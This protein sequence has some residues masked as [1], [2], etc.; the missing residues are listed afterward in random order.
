MAVQVIAFLL[1]V[2]HYLF[3]GTANSGGYARRSVVQ[4]IGVAGQVI[5]TGVALH[6]VPLSF[7]NIILAFCA[8]AAFSLNKLSFDGKLKY[9]DIHLYTYLGTALFCLLVCYDISLFGLLG[10]YAGLLLE[11]GMISLGSNL[12]FFDDRTDDESGDTFGIH[13][14]GIKVPR[15]KTEYRIPLAV[16]S[17]VAIGAVLMLEWNVTIHELFGKVI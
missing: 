7:M 17:L 5:L 3:T 14:L 1:V 15:L 6:F 9:G 2:A 10:V 11:K 4:Y 12:D 13:L 16:V 8:C